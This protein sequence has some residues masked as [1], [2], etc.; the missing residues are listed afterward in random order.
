MPELPEVETMCRGIADI[1]GRTISRVT[2]PP[3]DYRPIAINPGIATINKR[4]ARKKVSRISRLGKRVLIH[5][6]DWALVI[7][8]KMT[9]LVS[10][11]DVPDTTHVRIQLDFRGNP[12]T[13]LQFW[14]RRGLGT[15]QLLKESEIERQL[16]S[17]R[18]GPD[19]LSISLAEFQER[20]KRTKRPIKVALLDQKLVAGI[21]NLYASEI[22][23]TAR[24]SPL[25]PSHE[26]SAPR[27]KRIYDAML[28][29]LWEAVE[30]EGSTLS[31]GTYRN[32]LND[33]GSYQNQHQVYDR[34]DQPCPACKQGVIA[35]IVQAQRST[36]YCPK[37]QRM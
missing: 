4:L 5:A 34:K 16:I 12:L 1:V 18:L 3:C 20:F 35:R 32:A 15:I 33:P 27:I 37:C 24:I 26:I 23:H 21:G 9:G 13:R 29:I 8:P 30:H 19:A 11:T 22:L 14:D 25:R 10:L 17:G 36:F 31:D 7:Q 6:D 2:T 28:Q